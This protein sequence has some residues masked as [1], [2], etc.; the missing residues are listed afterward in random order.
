[1]S[2]SIW[3]PGADIINV[4]AE[5]SNLSQVFTATASQ[6]LFTL[7]AF[8]YT[9]GGESIAVYRGGQRLIK[10][11]DWVETTS[12]SITVQG[13]TLAAGETIEVVAVLGAASDASIA[14][15]AS[16]ASA[17]ASAA[18]AA[19]AD[20]TSDNT[21]TFTNKTLSLSSNTLSGT[22]AEFNLALTDG[23]FA[24]LTGTQTLQNKTLDSTNT[25][26]GSIS[27]ASGSLSSAVNIAGASGHLAGFRNRIING[28]FDVWQRGTSFVNPG[29]VYTADRWY[30]SAVNSTVGRAT[31]LPGLS[32]Y[33]ALIT[34]SSATNSC[35]LSQALESLDCNVLKGKRVTLSFS[36]HATVA[37]PAGSLA[38]SIQRNG[39]ADTQTG[40]TWTTLS[41]VSGS[42]SYTP[43][44]STQY[45]SLTVDIPGDATA[46]GIRVNIQTTNIA[47]GSSVAIYQVQL[48][49]GSV[50]TPFE[51][52]P[53][54]AE[55]ALCQRF[56]EVV[57]VSAGQYNA[58]AG[59][60]CAVSV[61]FK[62]TK[63]A[64]PSV[65]TGTASVSSNVSSATYDN[66]SVDG[67]RYVVTAVG[68]GVNA[69][70]ADAI[71][72]CELT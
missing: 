3:A 61:P 12:T 24:T 16:A 72:V 57:R 55:L 14:A 11:I 9:V 54:S 37:E 8:S 49:V 21:R 29:G 13:I 47:N 40:G 44:T 39:T 67:A 50:A 20:I 28:N 27:G 30:G 31:G 22:L 46:N 4:D 70:T 36:C 71:A 41:A 25:I 1:M 34:A 15:A 48:E 66:I 33:A 60:S 45:A 2:A 58:A 18:S 69:A 17:A 32:N 7:T 42:A 65:S 56:Y 6:T 38:I 26:N 62:V 43:T 59:N 53:I 68:S 5:S 63:R 51:H 35:L 23:D 10:G 52:R 64:L 19:L